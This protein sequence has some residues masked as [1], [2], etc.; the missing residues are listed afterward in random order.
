MTSS[1]YKLSNKK[2]LDDPNQVKVAVDS[3]NY[4]ILFT[5]FPDA[6]SLSKMT[7]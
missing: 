1:M 3:D 7:S 2:A 6:F 4:A 5:R